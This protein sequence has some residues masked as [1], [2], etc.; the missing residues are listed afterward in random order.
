MLQHLAPV[1]NP[2]RNIWPVHFRRA[3]SANSGD[4]E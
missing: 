1:D 2:I 3:M 4:V